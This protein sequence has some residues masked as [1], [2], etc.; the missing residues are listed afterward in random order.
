MEMLER[1]G[2]DEQKKQWLEPLLDGKIRS[3]FAMTEPAV[4]SS[5]ATNIADGDPARRRR[6]RH[7]R[8]QV[9][10]L[11]HQRPA[12]QDPDR[13]GQDRP[14]RADPRPAEHDPGAAR[15]AG[16]QDRALP[17]GV[18]LRRRAARPRRGALRERARAREQ[19]PARRGPRLRD[20]P[21]ASRARPHPPLHARD[22]RGRARAREDV[23]APDDARGLRQE[24]LRA[25]ASGRSASPTPASTSSARAC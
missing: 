21:G 16:R 14:E 22:R 2:T 18:R 9:V 8:P 24:D 19:H 11:R 1:Y 10:D 4:A 3:A 13:D 23:R 12:L 7:Q 5:D 25:L 17:P 15:H 6:V 20:R